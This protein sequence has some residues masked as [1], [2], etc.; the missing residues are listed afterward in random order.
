[1]TYRPRR[2]AALVAAAAALSLALAACSG[3]SSS[4]SGAD[5]SADAGAPVA[6]G[7]LTFSI[8]NDPISLN[9]S[10][11]GSGNDTL[12]VTRQL[13]DSLLYQDPKDGSLQPWLASKWSASADAKDFTFTLRDGV[14]FSDGTPLT[15]QSVKDTFDDIVKNG[16]KA[17]NAV[18]SFV[19]LDKIVVKDPHTVEVEFKSPNAAFPQATS[20]VG[21]GILAASTLKTPYDDRADGKAIV[22]SGPFVLDHYT[23]NV[24]TVLKKRSGYTWAPAAFKNTQGAYLGSVTFKVVPEAGVRTGTL[25]SD[26][27]DAIG[28]VQ[29]NDVSQIENAGLPV[30]DRANP[31]VTFGITFNEASPLGKDQNI[32]KAVSLAINPQEVRDTALNDKFAVATSVLGITTPGYV[33]ESK[34]LVHDPAQAKQVL[35]ADGWTP[36]PDGIRVKDGKKLQLR[37]PWIANFAPNQTVL[38][39]IQQEL[40]AVG[41]GVTL[42]S[43]PVPD[44]LTTLQSGA[45]DAS[46]GNTS[47]ADGDI[48]RTSF[49]SAATNYY[50]I[51]DP[52]LEKLLQEQLAAGDTTARNKILADAQARIISQY[53]QIPVHELTSIIGTQK[54]VHGVALGADSR[55]DSLVD[56]WKS[57]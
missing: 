24:E 2:T 44:Y 32:R 34:L 26:Q 45:F 17:I 18:T 28:G 56:A 7:A 39:L 19:G 57:K 8:Q 25:T 23:K 38:E 15:A 36:G 10:G 5:P 16:A 47:R 11:T 53:H 50:K 43:S 9:P 21:L 6:G 3:G 13:V 22:G 4:G 30:I 54:D 41:I 1:M 52:T 20:Q 46:W 33:D 27:A 14:T 35:D 42:T 31:G 49:S 48:L 37:L 51:D 29:P 12:Y 40:K 55:L